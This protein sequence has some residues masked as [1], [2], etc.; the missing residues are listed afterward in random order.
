[1]GRVVF[2]GKAGCL[3][4][5]RQVAALRAAHVEVEV[6]DLL[7]TTWR[8][9]DLWAYFKGL[10]QREWVN[11]RAAAVKSGS[12]KPEE[13]NARALLSALVGD[14]ILIRR[15]LLVIEGVRLVGFD[16][17]RLEGLLGV[18]LDMTGEDDCSRLRGAVS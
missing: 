17:K 12:F 8:K 10:D 18:C 9:E 13:T 11:P 16:Q 2:H 4:N 1:M 6:H 7:L 15:P 3:T 5:R 14:P